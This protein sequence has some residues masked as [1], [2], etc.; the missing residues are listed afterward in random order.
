MT[1]IYWTLTKMHFCNSASSGVDMKLKHSLS[2]Q[3]HQISKIIIISLLTW[4]TKPGSNFTKMT[5]HSQ[6]KL[7]HDFCVIQFLSIK[8]KQVCHG[9]TAVARLII[10]MG[11]FRT[12]YRDSSLGQVYSYNGY[13]TT[14]W[15]RGDQV[16]CIYVSPGAPVTRMD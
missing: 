8:L 6:F 9:N 13:Q 10:M 15:T 1:I 7:K 12:N 2:S 4:K 3:A 16:P 5:F 11:I 14:I